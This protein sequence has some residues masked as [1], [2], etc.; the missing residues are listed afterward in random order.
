[1]RKVPDFSMHLSHG[2]TFQCNMHKGV[3]LFW[4]V[5]VRDV[6]AQIKGA[7]L[8]TTLGVGVSDNRDNDDNRDI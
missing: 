3:T 1:M 5:V 4:K 6:K 2:E 7:D 8:A